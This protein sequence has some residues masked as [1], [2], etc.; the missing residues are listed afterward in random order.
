LSEAPDATNPVAED[1]SAP[2]VADE[3]QAQGDE[4]PVFDADKWVN[5]DAAPA[6][7]EGDGKTVDGDAVTPG[8]A[9]DDELEEIEL[10]DGQKLKVP[11][12]VALDRLR[13]ADYTRKTQELAEQRRAVET[14][15][16]AWQRQQAESVAALPEEHAKVAY[17]DRDMAAI[18]AQ[19]D[20]PLDGRGTTLRTIDWPQ[21]RALAHADPDQWGQTYKD[22]RAAYDA[23]HETLADLQR[24]RGEAVN[25]LKTKEAERLTAQRE[26]AAQGLAKRQE[27]TGKILAQKIEGWNADK[28]AQIAQHAVKTY[29]VEPQEVAEMTD[30]RVWQ[31]LNDNLSLREQLTKAQAALKQH[32]TAQNNAKAQ[33][34]Q[35]APKV[36]GAAPNVRKTTDASGDQLSTEEWARRERERT[37]ARRR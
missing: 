11:K 4:T 7:E 22:Y 34:S 14:E 33:A 12:E 35:P 5:E 20:Q 13:H 27:E 21:F 24:T 37:A 9:A 1:T 32:Q 17:I 16:E 29:G 18:N 10:S 25:D 30:P 23:A 31:V 2:G 26:Q 36:G 19:L 6:T 8:E 3:A 15:R 28:A